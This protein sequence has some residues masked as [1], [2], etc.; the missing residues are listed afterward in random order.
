VEELRVGVV[1]VGHHGRQ[2]VRIYRELPGV[3]ITAVADTDSEK[4][5]SVSD[6]WGVSTYGDYCDI[7]SEVD[8][9]SIASPTTSHH[10][11]ANYFL[12]SGKHVFVEK[13]MASTVEEAD[14]LIRLAER[15]E[16]VLQ[17]GHV[18]RFNPAIK[19]LTKLLHDPGFIECHRLCRYNPRGCDVGVV[20]DLM[21]HD[22]DI[23]LALV[24]DRIKSISAVGVNVLSDSEDI[25]SARI[26]FEKGCIANLTASRVSFDN[27]RK[28]RIFQRDAY[29]SLDYEKQEGLIYRK[30]EG[31][32]VRSPVPT[33]KAEPL[34]LE[35]E[36]FVR[37]IKT[38]SRPPVSAEQGRR[39]LEIAM[40]IVRHIQARNAPA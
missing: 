26:E 21:I 6:Q 4:L 25:A 38:S 39:A 16:R 28:I 34:K 27:M 3:A 13:P 17:I 19:A 15:N 12:S 24:N 33:Q 23:I 22:I 32:I 18:E 5:K 2:H 37:C 7:A 1:G 36:S 35:L 20:L 14:D 10:E 11:I 9:V 29:I 8:A 31:K 40:E 30:Q